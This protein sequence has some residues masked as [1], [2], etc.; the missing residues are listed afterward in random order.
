MRTIA[1]L[2]CV[3]S[4]LVACNRTQA[5]ASKKATVKKAVVKKNVADAQGKKTDMITP[6]ILEKAIPGGYHRQSSEDK[7]IQEKANQALA[8]LQKDMPTAKLVKIQ[9]AATQVVA[10][11]NYF[12]CLELD[13][14]GKKEI[15]NVVMFAG[16]DKSLTLTSKKRIK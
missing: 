12:F 15:W 13:N 8:L 1:C 3:I 16:L 6:K 5:P 11:M 14:A 4:C 2:C 10:G 9:D 7:S